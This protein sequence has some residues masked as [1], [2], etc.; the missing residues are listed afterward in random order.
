M[1]M[2]QKTR[3]VIAVVILLVIVGVVLAVD[4]LQRQ[5]AASQAPADMPPGSIPIYL[6]GKF[7]DSFVPDDLGELQGASFVD[8]EEGKTQE[9]WLLNDVLLLYV[10][11]SQLKEDMQ[12]TVSS[13]SREKAKT[14]TWP[15]VQD[16]DN[17]VMFDLSG[18]GTLKLVSK[19]PGFDIRDEW[20]QDVDKIEIKPSN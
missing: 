10:K 7:V 3:I 16:M 20:I 12:I 14:L 19:I 18:R 4:A 17:M 13:S 8:D 2:N 11:S 5:Q 15:E 6:D 1:V 9:G